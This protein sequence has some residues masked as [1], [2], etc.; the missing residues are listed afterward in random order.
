MNKSHVRPLRHDKRLGILIDQVGRVNLIG[1]GR[2]S[3]RVRISTSRGP[4]VWARGAIDIMRIWKKRQLV[5]NWYLCGSVHIYLLSKDP[6]VLPFAEIASSSTSVGP[7]K[8][9]LA[10]ARL[11]LLVVLAS[12]KIV[13]KFKTVY[14][15]YLA[16][17]GNESSIAGMLWNR[18][19][20]RYHFCVEILAPKCKSVVF[21]HVPSGF[22]A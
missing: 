13:P 21:E 6:C 20:M 19:F 18:R 2:V 12:E 22:L 9:D 17:N 16:A 14:R 11:S 8:G 10:H 3:L 5:Q 15:L 1:Q 7:S 4:L